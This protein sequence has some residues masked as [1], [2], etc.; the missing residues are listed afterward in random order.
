VLGGVDSARVFEFELSFSFC[1]S[2]ELFLALLFYFA[3]IVAIRAFVGIAAFS[4]F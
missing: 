3:W 1:F 4:F 2:F